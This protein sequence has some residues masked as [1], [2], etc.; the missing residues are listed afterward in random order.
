MTADI[1]LEPISDAHFTVSTDL[2]G[3]GDVYDNEDSSDEHSGELDQTVR[4]PPREVHRDSDLFA[5]EEI[6]G[7]AEE[8]DLFPTTAHAI[9]EVTRM[10]AIDVPSPSPPPPDGYTIMNRRPVGWKSTVREVTNE[11]AV[12]LEF[13]SPSN[14]FTSPTH[15]GRTFSARTVSGNTPLTVKGRTVSGAMQ[16]AMHAASDSSR[17]AGSSGAPHSNLQDGSGGQRGQIGAEE[18]GKVERES[19][20]LGLQVGAVQQDE[21]IWMSYVRQQLAALFPGFFNPSQHS[22]QSTSMSEASAIMS[23]ARAE[24]QAQGAVH[25]TDEV[26]EVTLLNEHQSV[27]EPRAIF[28][29]QESSQ[30]REALG[31]DVIQ[32]K[33]HRRPWDQNRG[34]PNLS[35]KEEIGGM[36]DEIERL[37]EVVS[38]LASG[39]VG[40]P[41]Q[42]SHPIPVSISNEVEVELGTQSENDG[43]IP[44]ADA[45]AKNLRSGKGDEDMSE[46]N[47]A[48]S[49]KVSFLASLSPRN[50]L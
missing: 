11:D 42:S 44:V 21:E 4:V 9:P 35:V 46:T 19:S 36:R 48:H 49:P 10:A 15:Q 27:Q 31:W 1:L 32:D 5:E 24:N 3:D 13:S 38:G 37:R 40:P 39:M 29:G 8:D 25:G 23:R 50:G 33:G 28:L 20:A 47:G 30:K 18:L 14:D 34:L 16:Y 6:S 17:P 7:D 22:D 45:G 43:G 2:D 12:S 41:P 26:R